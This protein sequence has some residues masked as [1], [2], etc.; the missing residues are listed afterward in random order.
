MKKNTG[1]QLALYPSPVIVVGA[2][3]DGKP[4]WTLVAHAGVMAHSHLML[5]MV[6]AH[7]TNKG[8][9]ENKV[10]SVNVVDSSWLKEADRMGCVSGNKTDKSG[11]FAYTLGEKGAPMI[12]AAKVSMECEVEDIYDL[13]GFDNF[14][15][16]IVGTYVAEE[17]LTENPA[18]YRERLEEFGLQEPELTASADYADGKTISFRIGDASAGALLIQFSFTAYVQ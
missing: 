1:A 7:Y 9:S 18:E 13:A 4:N 5:S 10:V 8:I 3:V 17:I 15:C 12:D 6:K 16:R 2:M 11:A 14:I